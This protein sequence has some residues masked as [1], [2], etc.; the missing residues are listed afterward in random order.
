MLYNT[1][2]IIKTRFT[3]ESHDDLYK[4]DTKRNLKVNFYYGL[5]LLLLTQLS[6]SLN[7]TGSQ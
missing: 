2:Y 4:N 7:L 5:L 6:R 1:L 3:H